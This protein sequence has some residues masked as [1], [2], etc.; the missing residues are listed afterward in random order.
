MDKILI[1][2][3]ADATLF[4]CRDGKQRLDTD[5]KGEV[6][7]LY[8]DINIQGSAGQRN[9]VI[10]PLEKVI[11]RSRSRQE[12]GEEEEEEERDVDWRTS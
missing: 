10:K 12:E 3:R 5:L 7:K 6:S 1:G 9:Q 8:R 2:T 11:E 4:S